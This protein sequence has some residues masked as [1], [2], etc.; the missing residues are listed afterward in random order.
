M[1]LA[2][3]I[4]AA[5]APRGTR[6]RAEK[7]KAYLKSTLVHLGVDVPTTRAVVKAIARE[8]TPTHAAL[9]RAVRALWARGIYELRSAAVELLI[10]HVDLLGPRDVALL[11]AL[12]RDAHT[13][14]LVDAIA[15]HVMGVLVVDHPSLGA[16]LDRWAKDDDFWLRRAAM[17]AL[18]VPLR[19]G[20]GDFARFTRYADAMLEE[21]AFF[22]RK[23]IGWILREASRPTPDR[24]YAWLLPRAARA[25]GLT[26][27]EATKHLSAKQRAEIVR[28]SRSPRAT[29]SAGPSSSSRRGAP[30]S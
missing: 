6:A 23:A 19:K 21:K 14:A 13:W 24:V 15:P 5:L 10:V 1:D 28:C 22:I 16:T 12:L 18:L 3:R 4:E 9:V 30:R 26:I 17:L 2:T 7:E 11:E 29:T 20:G 27:R 25:A 8:T